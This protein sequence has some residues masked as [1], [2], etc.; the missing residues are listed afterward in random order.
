MRT[1]LGDQEDQTFSLFKS[2]ITHDLKKSLFVSTKLISSQF[3]N[4]NLTGSDRTHSESRMFDMFTLR[5]PASDCLAGRAVCRLAWPFC[6]F[7]PYRTCFT[8]YSSIVSVINGISRFFGGERLVKNTTRIG[9]QYQ[10]KSLLGQDPVA[11]L[12]LPISTADPS[13]V[14][15][16][17]IK[18][19]HLANLVKNY[20]YFS[21]SNTL[22]VEIDWPQIKCVKPGLAW[23]QPPNPCYLSQCHKELDFTGHK[24]AKSAKLSACVLITYDGFLYSEEFL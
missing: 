12:D 17:S 1:L 14:A 13:I 20:A 15:L 7:C 16:L 18:A 11:I 24:S 8:L 6:R 3:L 10:S 23:K 5:E 9:D 22:I 19:W 4:N 2:P 21:R